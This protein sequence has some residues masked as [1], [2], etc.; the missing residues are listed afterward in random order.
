M[1]FDAYYISMVSESYKGNHK[2]KGL[3]R[4]LL[5]NRKAKISGEYSSNIFVLRAFK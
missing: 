2:L 1:S 4:G 5:S 3:Y